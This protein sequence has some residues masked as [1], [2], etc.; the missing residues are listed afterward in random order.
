[1]YGGAY[2]QSKYKNKFSSALSDSYQKYDIIQKPYRVFYR[3]LFEYG[4]KNESLY[5]L[6]YKAYNELQLDI[7]DWVGPGN[8][9]LNADDELKI[10]DASYFDN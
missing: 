2:K 4:I 8:I 6:I 3:K 10:I 1:M 5:F 7:M 9:G